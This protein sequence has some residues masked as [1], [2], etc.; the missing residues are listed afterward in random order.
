MSDLSRELR[1]FGL[2]AT[3][4][5]LYGAAVTSFAAAHGQLGLLH[6]E[7]LN[8]T[9]AAVWT[10]GLAFVFCAYAADLILRRRPARPLRV[11]AAEFRAKVLPP[12]LLLARGTIILGWFLLM[13]FFTPF[14]IMI[15]H[16]RGFPFDV[17]LAEAERSLLAGHDSWELTHALFGSAPATF[18]LHLAYNMWFVMMWL[19]IIYIMLRTELTRLRA[20]YIVAFLLCWIVVGSFGAYFLASA[21]P[22]YYER[23]FGDPH[24]RPLMDRLH[25]LDSEMNAIWPGFGVHALRLQDMLWASFMSKR[26]LFGGGISA[27]P[28]MHVSIAVLMACGGWQLGRKPGWLLTIFAGMIWAGSVHLGWHYALDGAVALGLTLAIWRL[29]GWLVD[30]FVLREAPSAAWQPALA[31]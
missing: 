8:G 14:K 13:V 25:A 1:L 7:S 12:D 28:S 2:V 26:E 5:A 17:A 31:E 15:G 21:G 10:I 29:S 23:A 19:G 11:M 20:R 24:F 27:M 4:L 9:M 22:C 3:V 6:I 30:R 18:A 16:V